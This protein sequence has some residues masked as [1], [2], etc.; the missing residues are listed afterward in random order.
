MQRRRTFAAQL[1]WWLDAPGCT[2]EGRI[3]AVADDLRALTFE[4]DE[5]GF[6]LDPASGVAC[7]HLLSDMESSP[8]L[9]PHSRVEDLRSR[10]VQIRS[11]FHLSTGRVDGLSSL[12]R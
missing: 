4:L 5:D 3:A 9:N 12:E 11:G 10:I 8:L 6:E 2:N 7:M 1:R